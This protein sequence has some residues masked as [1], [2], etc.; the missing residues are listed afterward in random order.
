MNNRTIIRTIFGEL[1]DQD[2]FFRSDIQT[3]LQ[4]PDWSQQVLEKEGLY[5]GPFCYTPWETELPY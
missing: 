5:A 3:L 4:I 2:R 1:S